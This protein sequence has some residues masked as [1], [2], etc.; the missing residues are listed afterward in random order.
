MSKEKKLRR[1]LENMFADTGGPPPEAELPPEMAASLHALAPEDSAALLIDAM[2]EPVNKPAPATA[3]V[4]PAA[5][6]MAEVGIS[7][8]NN[9]DAQAADTP[10]V[11]PTPQT[12]SAPLKTT[13]S[14]IGYLVNAEG[15]TPAPGWTSPEIEAAVQQGEMVVRDAEQSAT[16][17]TLAVPIQ[18]PQQVLGALNFFDD[19]AGHL[20][21]EDD[22]ALV[23]A[24]TDQ[25]ALALQNARLLE[26]ITRERERLGVLYDVLQAFITRPNRDD[27]ISTALNL[28]P[29]LGA[30]NAYLVLLGDS[31]K[32]AEFHSNLPGF[33]AFTPRQLRD[34]A[35]QITRAGLEKWV[36]DNRRAAIITDA[37]ADSRWMESDDTVNSVIS[38]PLQTQRGALTGALG[39]THRQTGAL[40]EEQLP[41][42]ESIAGQVAVALENVRLRDQQATQEYNATAL[43]RAA[44]ALTRSLEESE[45][46]QI[47]AEQLFE[48]FKPNALLITRWD[49]ANDQF[50]TVAV[51]VDDQETPEDRAA[52][53]ALGDVCRTEAKPD[54]YDF[55]QNPRALVRHLRDVSESKIRESVLMPLTYSGDVE[56]VAELIHTGSLTGFSP[57]DFELFES[58]LNAWG[59]SLQSARLYELQRQTAERLAEV[60][61]LKS[62]FLANMSHELRTPLNSII[63]FSR[64]ILKGIDGPLTD[65]QIQDLTSINNSGQHL[66]GLINSI[67]DLAKIEAGKMELVF[68]EVNLYDTIKIVMSTSLALVKDKPIQL[69]QDV[70]AELPNVRADGMRL[71]QILLNLLSNA[72]KFTEDGSVTL[73]VRKTEALHPQTGQIAPYV[74]MSVIDTG[75]GIAPEDMG[76]LFE[77]FSQVDASATRKVGGTGLGL[78]I[79]R[80]LIELHHGRIWVESEVNKGSSFTF[81]IPVSQHDAPIESPDLGKQASV[82]IVLAVD[83]DPGIMTLYRRYLEPNGF[84]VAGVTRSTE[85]ITRAAELRPLVILL[86]VLMP[87]KDGWQVLAELKRSDITRDIPVVMCTLVTDRE[88]AMSMGAIDYLSKPILESDLLRV[89]N[90]I[91]TRANSRKAKAATK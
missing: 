22:L 21:S 50:R 62:Q 8:N 53:P 25:L 59:T 85:V 20:W 43:A 19:T 86:D 36:L 31:A 68:D 24:V 77:Q 10:P 30:Q 40:T 28:A 63:G 65:L 76:K 15:L 72:S 27:I 34:F 78:N 73:R 35:L 46:N 5:L 37:A 9:G 16:R 67:L 7:H 42:I 3:A 55:V 91:Q 84:K 69:L 41:L 89:L 39:Y 29:R 60:D 90:K 13:S 74:E 2:P 71:R 82:P 26:E 57:K 51:I 49:T 66:L 32:N 44:Q 58:I 54:Y 17:A 79:C 64:V 88:R 6:P 4:S 48:A 38:V 33:S 81:I 87:H 18:L 14:G 80:H 45:V 47:L 11:A 1:Q 75:V 52:Y 12:L 56:G 23:Q 61:R 70:E 83:D